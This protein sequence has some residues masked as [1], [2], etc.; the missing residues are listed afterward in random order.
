M[1]RNRGILDQ[2]DKQKHGI[3]MDDTGTSN[4]T[5]SAVRITL[6]YFAFGFLWIILSDTVLTNLVADFDTMIQI[7]IYKGWLFILLTSVLVFFLVKQLEFR[8]RQIEQKLRISELQ[9]RETNRELEIIIDNI[10]ARL[11]YKDNRNN[12]L[13]V[14]RLAAEA[15]GISAESM[16]GKPTE[17]FF[18]EHAD[19]YYQDDLEVIRSGQPKLG[20]IEKSPIPGK[21]DRWLESNKIPIRVNQGQVSE[22]LIV[23]TDVTER[24]QTEDDLQQQRAL[25]EAIFNDIPDALMVADLE[26]K[27]FMSNPST[28]RI[29]GY[30]ENEIIGK[31]AEILYEN[32]DEFEH[33]GEL[34]F[35]RKAN[36]MLTPY[37]VN[38]RR[39]NGE[40]FPGESIGAIIK[41]LDGQ[42]I[43][44]LAVIR[45]ISDRIAMAQETRDLRESLAHVSRLSTMSEMTAGI[46]HEINQP[47]TA[48]ANYAL[49]C[50][51]LFD[52]DP[53]SPKLADALVKISDQALRAGDIIRKLRDF[54]KQR[55]SRH[56]RVNC[57]EMIRKVVQLAELDTAMNGISVLLKLSENLP[58]VSIDSVQIQ[59]VIL[60][61]I[62]NGADAI[63][64]ARPLQA[65]ICIS[66]CL[67]TDNK[68]LISVDDN[69]AGIAEHIDEKIFD[70]FVSTKATGMG[71]GLSISRT[72]IRSHGGELNYTPRSAGGSVFSFTLPVVTG[73]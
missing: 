61:L 66:S 67:D 32:K 22:I 5:R 49:A 69:G 71:M 29:F 17:L 48:I 42:A 33:Q 52:T 10:P 54:I 60:N 31:N 45:D 9:L 30:D 47:L 73:E 57:N 15:L 24:K 7:G 28:S 25:L 65:E 35:N 23:A 63:I 40:V 53:T 6:I 43:G 12:I 72:I 58:A 62:R 51:R 16:A 41:D 38:Y 68:V 46:A 39:K 64:A 18:P 50:R 14:N 56:E 13:R 4:G 55:E 3:K 59:Q 27:I 2:F 8:Q 21:P 34:R 37:L 11:V 44:F 20:V 1:T 19:R 36:V 70:P 26:R